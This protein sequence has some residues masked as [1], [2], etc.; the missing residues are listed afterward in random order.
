M[1]ATKAVDGGYSSLAFILAHVPT[2]ASRMEE[3]RASFDPLLDEA[4][5]SLLYFPTGG[6]KSEAFYG[7]LIFA[8]FLDRL[9]DKSRGVTAM[10]RY[11]LRLLTL[12]QGQRLLRL[13]TAAELVRI[14]RQVSGW[15]FEI[16]F[17]VG[18]NNTPNR[19]SYVPSIVPREDDADHPD[20]RQ[21]EEEANFTIPTHNGP[22]RATGSFV[23]LSTKCLSALRAEAR[24][25]YVGLRVKA[26]QRDGWALSVLMPSA[27]SIARTRC[28]RR[29]RSC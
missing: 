9:R 4:A 28:E 16:G 5:A 17:W 3:Y 15:P 2:F 25:D 13:V 26:L 27:R 29:Y 23:L 14:N 1:A 22:P 10:I 21:L 20:D 8:M 18:G 7:T 12:Q 24:R 11:P 6:G 19:Y